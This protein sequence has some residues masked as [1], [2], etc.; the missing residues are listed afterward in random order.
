MFW[1]A[2]TTA[3][4]T[5]G[6][7][8]LEPTDERMVPESAHKAT[9]WEH[10][11]RYAFASRFVGQKRVLDIACGEGYGAAA[12]QQ[13]GAANVI[14]VE[15]SEAVCEHARAKY[16]L[17]VRPGS[18][19][20]IPL[21]DNSID[22]VVSFETIEHL[23]HPDHFLDECARVLVPGGRL[24]ISTPNKGIYEYGDALQ[25][26]YHLS[27]MTAQE[28]TS[29][30]RS[31]FQNARL[32]VQRTTSAPWWSVRAL[33]SESTPLLRMPGF[34]RVRRFL[35]RGVCP[36]AIDDPT[37]EQRRS[38]V[39]LIAKLAHT[40]RRLLNPYVVLPYR[41]WYHE[42]SVYILASAIRKV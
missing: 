20:N 17:D 10:V 3:R 2:S 29:A 22:V 32:F 14:G 26:P 16:G 35:Q 31:R 38:A 1:R 36:E 13:S 34:F 18:A 15:I 25:N 40:R 21:D 42:N 39:D 12:L 33:A 41:E 9:F 7:A 27:E 24:I 23:V 37:D 11:Y 19:E 6:G 8:I 5:A 28:F 30:L 4:S